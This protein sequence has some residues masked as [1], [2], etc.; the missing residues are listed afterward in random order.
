MATLTVSP[1]AAPARVRS[2]RKPG[3]RILELVAAHSILIAIAIMVLLPILVIAGT[4]FMAPEQVL[5]GDLLPNPITFENFPKVLD[6]VPFLRYFTNT[7]IIATLTTLAVLVS[8]VPAAYALS[9]LRFPGRRILFVLVLEAMMLPGQVTVIPLYVMFA[10][11]GWIGTPLPLLLPPLLMDAFSIFLLR[12]FF[13]TVPRSY[14]ES[15][16]LDGASEWQVLTR[17]FLPMVKSAIAAVALFA[18]FFAWN[19]YFNPL[20]YLGSNSEWFTLSV[21][22]ASFRS[23][24]GVEWNLMMAAT[25]IFIAPVMIV[26]FFA[27]KVFVQGI[28]LT[29]V[30]G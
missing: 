22:L 2:R 7:V 29:G 6:A 15:A 4:A 14:L 28:S 9:T 17:V 27:Q 13:V 19:D 18:F 26:F 12:Q 11:L 8:S 10:H 1:T 30:K 23:S 25:L 5:N 20:L 16:R 21:A 3:R 24:H